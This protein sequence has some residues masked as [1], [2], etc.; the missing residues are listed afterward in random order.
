[1]KMKRTSIL[2]NPYKLFLNHQNLKKIGASYK[3]V[4]LELMETKQIDVEGLDLTE[5]KDA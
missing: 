2:R 4:E 1:M 3:E 5:N